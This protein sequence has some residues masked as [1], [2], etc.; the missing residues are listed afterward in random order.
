MQGNSIKLKN[1]LI[2]GIF[3][4]ENEHD[5]LNI[6]TDENSSCEFHPTLIKKLFTDE[7]KPL[8]HKQ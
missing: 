2:F 6:N 3:T 4:F 1:T 7:S 8:L 5:S